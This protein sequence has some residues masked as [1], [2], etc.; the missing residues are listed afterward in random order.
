MTVCTKCLADKADSEFYRRAGRPKG[1][2]S[3]CKFCCNASSRAQWGKSAGKYAE[4]A[5]K[6][7]EANPEKISAA[8]ERSGPENKEKRRLSRAAHE[9]RNPGAQAAKARRFRENN[10]RANAIASKRW[11]IA[12]PEANAASLKKWQKKNPD[13]VRAASSSKR[14]AARRAI[15]RWETDAKSRELQWRK[16]NPGMTLDHIV[17]ISPPMAVTLGAKPANWQRRKSFVGPLIPLVYG[18][19]T[20]ANWAPLLFHE[21]ARKGNRDWPDSPWS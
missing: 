21:N 2:T 9:I 14:A 10:P 18:F 19:H 12:N 16:K 20:E 6:W 1:I 11:R 8:R 3:Q 17:P 4:T 13:K 5:K 7:R 15:P